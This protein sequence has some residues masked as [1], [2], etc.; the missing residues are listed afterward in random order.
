MLTDNYLQTLLKLDRS[1]SKFPDQLCAVLD[2]TEFSDYIAGLESDDLL[3]FVEYLDKVDSL[4][5][6]R[7]P[8]R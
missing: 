4:H 1:S 8:V 7:M 6:S 5:Q 2:R 3:E